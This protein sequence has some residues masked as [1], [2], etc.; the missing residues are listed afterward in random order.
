M[1]LKDEIRLCASANG[2]NKLIRADTTCSFGEFIQ[3]LRSTFKL[4]FLDQLSVK[5]IHPVSRKAYLVDDISSLNEMD[6]IEITTTSKENQQTSPNLNNDG[7]SPTICTKQQSQTRRKTELQANN[8]KFNELGSNLSLKQ[9]I[10][11]SLQEL[12]D[13]KLDSLFESIKKER[14]DSIQL[15]S[16][17]R[18]WSSQNGFQIKQYNKYKRK[19]GDVCV[20]FI[21]TSYHKCCFKL[22]FYQDKSTGT[23]F[24]DSSRS[25]TLHKHS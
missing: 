25:I 14:I 8:L 11:A 7:D 19:D 1:N 22:S 4:S 6:E 2:E 17:I 9:K 18:A 13:L 24:Y 12:K 23:F 15:T 20:Q 3:F 21:C 10:T 5:K 16:K